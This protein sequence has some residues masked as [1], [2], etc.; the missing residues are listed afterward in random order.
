MTEEVT[1]LF[2]DV[3]VT[4][5]ERRIYNE[6]L[7]QTRAEDTSA[8]IIEDDPLESEKYSFEVKE[9]R[10]DENVVKLLQTR[11]GIEVDMEHLDKDNTGLKAY[12]KLVQ[13]PI[14]VAGGKRPKNFRDTLYR[15]QL[16][17]M[18]SQ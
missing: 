14:V 3:V 8:D 11:T 7:R 12:E 10:I 13:V 4:E 5:E 15:T 1:S 6:T 9:Y 17:L 2:E 16:Y 18:G